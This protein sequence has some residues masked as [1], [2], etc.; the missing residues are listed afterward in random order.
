[1]VL[2]DAHD[3]PCTPSP[4][5]PAA[6]APQVLP[7]QLVPDEKEGKILRVRLIMKEGQKL[8]DPTFL[9]DEGST[10]SWIPCGRKLTCSFP[11]E[12]CG[13]RQAC[14]LW[15]GGKGETR[16]SLELLNWLAL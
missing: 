11:G 1:M 10:V 14:G 13:R 4:A 2:I 15:C 5:A 16:A 3:V 8:F 12:R 9:F 7:T 6:P